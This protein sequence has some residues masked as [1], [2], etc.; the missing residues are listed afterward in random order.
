M[1]NVMTKLNMGLLPNN[2]TNYLALHLIVLAKFIWRY[3]CIN[4]TC[5]HDCA[6]HLVFMLFICSSV[7]VWVSIDSGV[8]GSPTYPDE[9]YY[10]P[11]QRG[12]R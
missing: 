8:E 6:L 2:C 5:H 1:N 7:I 9:P 3:L 11:R 4:L 10:T 12:K